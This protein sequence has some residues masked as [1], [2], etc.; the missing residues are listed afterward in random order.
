VRNLFPRRLNTRKTR[1][2]HRSST[3]EHLGERITP[4]INA[5]FF[6]GQLSVVG[7]AAN[8]VIAVS[9]D[10]AGNIQVNGGAVR[11]QG[12]TANVANTKSIKIFGLGGDDTLSLDEAN[13]ILPQANIF[14]GAGNDTLTGGSAADFLFGDAGDD[15]LFGK[16]GADFLFG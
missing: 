1:K 14:G 4:A 3:F 12:G 8:N 13:G 9:R 7:D 11:V 2:M 10:L 16:G 5:F 6:H 15:N